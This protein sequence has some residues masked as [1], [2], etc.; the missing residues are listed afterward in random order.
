MA[1]KVLVVHVDGQ[2]TSFDPV[3]TGDPSKGAPCTKIGALINRIGFEAHYTIKPPGQLWQVAKESSKPT[4]SW[5]PRGRRPEIRSS[6]AL[7][8]LLSFCCVI[9][10]P[11]LFWGFLTMMIVSWAPKPYS[12]YE[13]PHI[14]VQGWMP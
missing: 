12:N 11:I 9:W 7:L 8:D 3:K 1:I 6:S 2:R 4:D 13:G 10:G 14:T 5:P